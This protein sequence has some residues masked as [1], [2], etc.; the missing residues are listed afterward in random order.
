MKSKV[1]IEIKI[2][3]VVEITHNDDETA[4]EAYNDPDFRWSDEPEL[5]E[6]NDLLGPISD[7]GWEIEDYYQ[8]LEEDK[9]VL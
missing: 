1:E 7:A 2:F 6:L 8:A 5:K 9:E 3:K 4:I